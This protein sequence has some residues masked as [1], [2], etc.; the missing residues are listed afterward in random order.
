MSVLTALSCVA[1]LST[2]SEC[3]DPGSSAACLCSLRCPVSPSS[4][5]MVSD[6]ILDRPLHVCAHCTVLR[7]RPLERA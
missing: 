1:V 2:A 5:Q 6:W 7:H 4:P 3:L